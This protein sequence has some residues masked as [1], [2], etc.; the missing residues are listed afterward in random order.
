MKDHKPYNLLRNPWDSRKSAE[1][2][3]NYT[4]P[5]F[6]NNKKYSQPFR[7]L[8]QSNP[9]FIKKVKK[10]LIKIMPYLFK[11]VVVVLVNLYG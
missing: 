4:T 5:L 6:L 8:H 11:L 9:L 7:V 2:P 3:R 10:K 1:I